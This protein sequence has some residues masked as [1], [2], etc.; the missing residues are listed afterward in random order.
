MNPWKNDT[1]L[2]DLMRRELYTPVIGD[3]LD[4]HDRRHQFLPQPIR[5]LLPEMKVAGRAMT[6]LMGAVFGRQEKP[7]GRMTEALDDLK[8]GEIYVAGGDGGNSANWG[9]I[10]T[11]AARARGAV[12]AV[13]DG[14]HRDTPKVLE[15]DFP[16]FSRGHYAQDSGPRMKVL[17]W[18]CPIEIGGVG[19]VSGDLIFGDIDGV[20]VIP[21][22]IAEQVIAESLEKARTEKRVRAEIER[23]MLATEAF[24]KFGVL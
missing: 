14:Y 7:F 23:G 22:D 19:I 3:I 21:G 17:E 10:L 1:E 8:S 9:E 11:A 20:V 12:G 2:F 5:P 18:R 16:V 6:V 4:N 15:Q 24:R 13:V